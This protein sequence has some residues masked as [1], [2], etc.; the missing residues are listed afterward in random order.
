MMDLTAGQWVVHA[1]THPAEGFEDMRWKKAGSLKI[2]AVILLLWFAGAILHG[3]MYGFQFFA[4]PE[5]VF[6]IVPFLVQTVV[7]FLAWVIGNWSV[8]TLLDGEGNMRNIAVYSAYALVPYVVSLYAE[9]LLS[10]ILIRDE[11]I[12]LQIISVTGTLWTAVLL[13]S[14]IRSV[15]QYTAFKTV[16]A[17]LLTI[18]AMLIMLF[19]LVLALSLLQNV[20]LFVYSVFTELMYRLKV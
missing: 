1:V 4:V 6:N 9:V 14:A 12:F 5:K 3:R 2:T 17:V 19:L 7:I 10:H 11:G 8:C 20:W 15:H 13:F 16:L 18:A